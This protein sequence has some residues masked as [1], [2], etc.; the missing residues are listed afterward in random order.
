MFTLNP[1]D[2]KPIYLQI[3]EQFIRLIASG[4]LDSGEKL[5]SVRQLATQLSINPNTIQRAYAEL[6]TEGYCYSQAGRGSFVAAAS[7]WDTSRR[8]ELICQLRTAANELR[9]LGMA[10]GE[11]IALVSKTE[12]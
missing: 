4:V 12:E 9:G 3:K 7:D 1:R 10:Q 5:P 8:A 6:E 2:T 11:L